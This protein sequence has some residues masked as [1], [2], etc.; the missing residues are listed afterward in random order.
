MYDNQAKS[1]YVIA[2]LGTL[3][4]GALLLP[5]NLLKLIP[6]PLFLSSAA[7]DAG[8]PLFDSE[9]LMLLTL[10]FAFGFAEL[11]LLVLTIVR[12]DIGRLV[13]RRRF[14]L[15]RDGG[16]DILRSGAELAVLLHALLEALAEGHLLCVERCIA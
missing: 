3:S 14:E 10:P 2:A 6:L 1:P 5:K 9:L 15:S 13:V 11:V 12:R 7:D 16:L 4:L 8:A